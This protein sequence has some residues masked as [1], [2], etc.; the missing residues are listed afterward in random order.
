MDKAVNG[1]PKCAKA[2]DIGYV[3]ILHVAPPLTFVEGK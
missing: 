2:V 3:A 1:A